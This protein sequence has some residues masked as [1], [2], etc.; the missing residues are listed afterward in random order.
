MLVKSGTEAWHRQLV[1]TT[2][3]DNWHQRLAPK[4]LVCPQK[5]LIT[6]PVPSNEPF[7]QTNHSQA[8]PKFG[9]QTW[10][11]S[12]KSRKALWWGK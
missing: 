7:E 1:Q 4:S 2:S 11:I 9:F 8:H 3:A 10:E 12:W 5:S 6:E